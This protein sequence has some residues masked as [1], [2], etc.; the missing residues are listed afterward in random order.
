MSISVI[1][2]ANETTYSAITLIKFAIISSIAESPLQKPQGKASE[3][4]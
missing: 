4:G 1:T 2:N 3:G